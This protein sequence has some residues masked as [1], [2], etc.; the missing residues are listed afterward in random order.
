MASSVKWG[1]GR[2]AQFI[3]FIDAE[4]TSALGNRSALESQW[5]SWHEQY[6]APAKQPVKKFPFEGAANYV[7]PITA[8]D[9]DVLYAKEMQSLHAPD[10]LW[11]LEALNERWTDAAHPMQ[12]CLAWLDHHVLHMQDVNSRINL[13]KYKLG[14]AVYKHGWL[15]ENRPV[16]TYDT[17]GQVVRAQRLRGRPFV[18]HVKLFDFLMPPY[19]YAIQPDEQ[20]GAPWLAER[21]RMHVDRLRSLAFASEPML[22]NLDKDAVNQILK[23]AEQG[24][25]TYDAKIQDMDYAKR[26]SGPPANFETSTSVNTKTPSGRAAKSFEVE[27]WEIHA[28]F[29]TGGTGG[30]DD[31]SR[32][33]QPNYDSQ[34]DIVVWYHRPTR[35]IV[36]AVYNPYLHGARPYESVGMF[37][38]EGFYKIGVCEQKEMFQTLQSEL[39]NFTIDNV[40]LG[41]SIGIVAKSGSNIVPGEPVYP[42]KVWITDGDVGKD[43]SSFKLGETYP[44]LGA[45]QGLV[46]ALGERRTGISDIQLGNVQDVPG[47]TPAETMRSMLQEGNRRPDMTLKEMRRGLGVVGLRVIQYLQ[48]YTGSPIE[49][50]GKQL[51]HMAVQALGMPEGMFAAQKLTSPQENAELGLGVSI[52]AT[53]GSANKEV[54]RQNYVALMQLAGQITPQ[55]IQLISIAQQAQGTPV[56]KV[57]LESALG[58]KELYVRALEQYDIKNISDV[59]PDLQADTAALRGPPP[60]PGGPPSLPAGPDGNGSGIPQG[61]PGEPSLEGVFQS[62]GIG[63]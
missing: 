13:E 4:I 51:L 55:F 1:R 2:L 30:S 36:R 22:P 3:E 8:T 23:F 47:R 21:N 44:D 16:W 38:S 32:P 40:L 15:Y 63:G 12:D 52:T 25:T 11:T 7:L 17:T 39:M 46:Q 5:L 14:T 18:D 6:R 56:G 27:L 53:S 54:E 10:N 62:L 20:G 28:R 19:S 48:Q 61:A 43:F 34:D 42:G 57:A 45:L 31:P 37:P 58:L 50:G 60:Q 9:I 41:N 33:I 29:P 35:Q 59:A 49:V 24:Q 26:G